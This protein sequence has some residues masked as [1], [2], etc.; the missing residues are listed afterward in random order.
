M[1]SP[2]K[3]MRPSVRIRP[4]HAPAISLSMSSRAGYA[5]GLDEW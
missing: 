1:G 3:F 4:D 2:A 5:N